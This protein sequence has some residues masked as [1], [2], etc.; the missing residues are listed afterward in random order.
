MHAESE[1]YTCLTQL[2]L[3]LL[4]EAL[5]VFK[6]INFQKKWEKITGKNNYSKFFNPFFNL[7]T[8]DS[9]IKEI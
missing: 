1:I 3:F 9:S 8:K 7:H 6:Q 2:N 5:L 4:I